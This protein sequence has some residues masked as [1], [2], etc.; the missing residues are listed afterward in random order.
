MG[1][2]LGLGV[3][4]CL[5]PVAGRPAIDYLLASIV[6]VPRVRVLVGYREQDVMAHVRMLRPDVVFVRD[7][8]FLRTTSLQTLQLSVRGLTEPFLLLD[9]DS[10]YGR[11]SL[12]RFRM[13]CADG[14]PM[15]GITNYTGASPT[16]AAV[17]ATSAGLSVSG[18]STTH[19]SEYAWA[20][21]ALLTPTLLT[22]EAC[23]LSEC[24]SK[25]LPI[26]A[27]LVDRIL[28]DTVDDLRHAEQNLAALTRPRQG[29][30]IPF[31]KR[32]LSRRK[33]EKAAS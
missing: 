13:A 6:D 30:L 11:D 15:L 26:R 23:P 32:R 3:P 19:V 29:T 5:V 20:K 17:R 14:K 9:G 8:A 28:L 22:D 2:G 7:P 10:I 12:A 16:Y 21:T 33:R 24:L 31:P 1:T 25:R 18:L 4:K 27:G